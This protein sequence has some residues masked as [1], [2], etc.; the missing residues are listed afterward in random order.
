MH[1]FEHNARQ[2]TGQLHVSRGH[3]GGGAGLASLSKINFVYLLVK[4]L[5]QLRKCAVPIEKPRSSARNHLTRSQVII[6]H[7][8]TPK[9]MLH[10]HKFSVP[11][12]A[13]RVREWLLVSAAGFD[14]FSVTCTLSQLRAAE[15][16]FPRRRNHTRLF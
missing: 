10:V 16:R 2:N 4:H 9:L 13:A 14:M 1:H 6:L 8:R 7:K 12:T 3:R 11:A 5:F 15:T